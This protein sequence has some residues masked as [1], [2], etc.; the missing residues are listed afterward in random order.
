MKRTNKIK[1]L[2]LVA[3]LALIATFGVA[4]NDKLAATDVTVTGMPENGVAIITDTENT[5]QLSATLTGG[6]GSVQ[7]RSGDEDVAT[8]DGSG[9]VTLMD[10]GAV[11][12]TVALANNSAIKAEVLLTVKD[13]RAINDT[14][15]L[16]GMPDTNTVIYDEGNVQLSAE[17][18]NASATLVW[19][20]IKADNLSQ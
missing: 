20:I 16:S 19:S 1:G 18:S 2:L 12:I 13:E 3:V 4:C 6:G 5:L 14:I 9:K 7:W 17:C 11:V 15:T 8:V 10:S